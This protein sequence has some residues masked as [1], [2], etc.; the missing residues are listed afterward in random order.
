MEWT[1]IFE[2]TLYLLALLNPAS[3]VLFLSTYEP[4][5]NS[6]Q[7][8]ELSW[9]SSLAALGILAAFAFI[10]QFVLKEI[11]RIDMYSLKITLSFNLFASTIFL[12]YR[13]ILPTQSSNEPPFAIAALTV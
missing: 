11:F 13:V 10:G 8:F 1:K 12:R 5:L 2:N 3:K 7:V 4:P 9:K 6:K